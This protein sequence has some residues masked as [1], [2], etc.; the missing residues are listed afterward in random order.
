MVIGRTGRGGETFVIENPLAG[1]R[2]TTAS[3]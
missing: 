2:A 1:V 3:R